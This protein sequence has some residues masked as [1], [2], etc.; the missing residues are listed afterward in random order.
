MLTQPLAALVADRTITPGSR[1]VVD[2][3]PGADTLTLTPEAR[4][5][6]ERPP[7]SRP[8]VLVLDDNRHLL[9]WLQETLVAANMAPVI[10]ESALEAHQAADRQPFDAAL[11]DVMLPDDDGITV[12]MQLVRQFPRLQVIVMTGMN[13]NSDEV[14]LTTRYDFPVL[15]KPF[16][17][18]DVVALLRARLG[19][20]G[21]RTVTAGT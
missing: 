21:P 19:Q 16:L 20:S 4:P 2:C 1:V 18:A 8:L 15:R 3:Q 9:D 14:L 13:L 5:E 6:S 17:A 7:L 10:A 11:I 12:A